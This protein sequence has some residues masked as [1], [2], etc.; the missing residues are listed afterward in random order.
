MLGPPSVSNGRSWALAGSLLAPTVAEPSSGLSVGRC[1]WQVGRGGG[2]W[3]AACAPPTGTPS[4]LCVKRRCR[5][6]SGPYW[7]PAPDPCLSPVCVSAAVPCLAPSLWLTSPR[8]P[9]WLGSPFLSVAPCLSCPSVCPFSRPCPL[10]APPLEPSTV[11]DLPSP[12]LSALCRVTPSSAGRGA[13]GR[14]PEPQGPPPPIGVCGQGKLPPH[15]VQ[16]T[17]QRYT[18]AGLRLLGGYEV[19]RPP[20]T[21]LIVALGCCPGPGGRDATEPC[22]LSP[23]TRPCARS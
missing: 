2:V 13:L 22:P 11:G 8:L 17:G 4:A 14:R 18:W 3:G 23:E 6:L 16:P 1:G 5:A 15:R 12:Q 7:V 20:R 9:C 21:S 19:F 10:W